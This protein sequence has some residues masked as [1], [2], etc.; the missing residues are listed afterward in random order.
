MKKGSSK[1]IKTILKRL[2]PIYNELSNVNKYNPKIN[3]I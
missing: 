1:S 2:Q 3:L